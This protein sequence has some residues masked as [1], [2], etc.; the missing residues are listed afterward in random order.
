MRKKKKKSVLY[1]D[2]YV[3]IP[4]RE[5]N[6]LAC[7]FF[8]TLTAGNLFKSYHLESIIV[9]QEILENCWIPL[10]DGMPAVWEKII[11]PF[12]S[13]FSELQNVSIKG[14]IR[15]AV[16]VLLVLLVEIA[17]DNSRNTRS[18]LEQIFKA[19]LRDQVTE[20]HGVVIFHILCIN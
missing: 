3:I 1:Y 17:E 15:K 2:P 5:E 16:Q 12:H 18:D 11:T 19:K 14:L 13:I 20:I 10:S 6:I 4:F 9:L 8:V 7:T